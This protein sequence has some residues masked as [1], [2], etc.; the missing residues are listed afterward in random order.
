[1]LQMSPFRQFLKIRSQFHSH[2]NIQ[3]QICHVFHRLPQYPMIQNIFPNQ[4]FE[5]LHSQFGMYIPIFDFV[6][7][8]DGQDDEFFIIVEEER[9]GV[10]N[11]GSGIGENGEVTV[12]ISRDAEGAMEAGEK[13]R[14]RCLF[15]HGE[16][17]YEGILFCLRFWFWWMMEVVGVYFFDFAFVFSD[18][19]IA[20][21]II[22]HFGLSFRFLGGASS[23]WISGGKV[24]NGIDII[25]TL[26]LM[27]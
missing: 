5:V 7:L 21:F 17:D 22:H 20:I 23:S 2:D 27:E 11:V 25:I 12:E 10:D 3:I 4:S 8:L 18:F 14:M 13:G 15:A 16:C 24:T 26:I 6:V 1:M 9:R 19:G